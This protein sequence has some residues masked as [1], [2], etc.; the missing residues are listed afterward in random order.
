MQNDWKRMTREQRA[1]VVGG[2][3][4][5]ALPAQVV[6]GVLAGATPR[7]ISPQYG[8]TF[9][10]ALILSA[11][12]GAAAPK[13]QSAEHYIEELQPGE[14]INI[15]KNAIAIATEVC[16]QIGDVMAHSAPDDVKEM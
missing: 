10:Q 1:H 14:V 9:Q 7:V 11:I 13:P 8:K 5:D 3:R 15:A 2:S 16:A 4:V 12:S 6:P